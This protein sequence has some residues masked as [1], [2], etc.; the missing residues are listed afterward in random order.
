[1]AVALQDHTVINVTGYNFQ[2]KQL[3]QFH[4]AFLY[5]MGLILQERIYS[6]RKFFPEQILSFKNIP[7]WNIFIM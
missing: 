7:F 2:G 1:M 3:C 5:N 4:F 6:R